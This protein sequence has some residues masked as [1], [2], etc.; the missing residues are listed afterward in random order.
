M[1]EISGLE[2]GRLETNEAVYCKKYFCGYGRNACSRVYR[3]CR[4]CKEMVSDDKNI[5]NSH[6]FTRHPQ[7]LWEGLYWTDERIPFMIIPSTESQV[8]FYNQSIAKKLYSRNKQ[9]P[10]IIAQQKQIYNA[11]DFIDCSHDEVADMINDKLPFGNYCCIVCGSDYDSF[12]TPKLVR[13]HLRTC[14]G[15]HHNIH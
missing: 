14:L 2:W 11:S 15:I 10:A 9:M 1:M 12:P 5:G 13:T 3:Y 8:A 6:E 4:L 7:T